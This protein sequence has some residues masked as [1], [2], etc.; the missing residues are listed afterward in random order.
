MFKLKRKVKHPQEEARKDQANRKHTGYYRSME[1][2]R[3]RDMQSAE[4]SE[5][6]RKGMLRCATQYAHLAMLGSHTEGSPCRGGE[7]G[8]GYHNQNTLETDEQN[9]RGSSNGKLQVGTINQGIINQ[10]T[11]QFGA[12]SSPFGASSGSILRR[13]HPPHQLME[14]YSFFFPRIHL[15]VYRI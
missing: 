11:I 7:R 5:A 13:G 12:W 15:D 2:G 6:E 14:R 3:G 10:G 1:N 9:R 4:V 8:E